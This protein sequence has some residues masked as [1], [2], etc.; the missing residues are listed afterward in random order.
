MTSHSGNWICVKCGNENYASR[1][2]CNMRKCGARRDGSGSGE[3]WICALC[4]NENYPSRSY[5]N[6]KTCGAPRESAD[7]KNAAQLVAASAVAAAQAPLAL[8]ASYPYYY[9]YTYPLTGSMGSTS[10]SSA[11]PPTSLPSTISPQMPGSLA[12][13]TGN[14]S[15][16]PLALSPAAA[17]A[18]AAA[19]WP[20]AMY[21][22]TGV[23]APP[24]DV[25]T[26]ANTKKRLN[27]DMNGQV[28][29]REAKRKRA[30]ARA[31][32]EG[33]WVCPNCGNL[34][35]PSRT[36]CNM[37][38]C[39]TPRPFPSSS[40]PNT[41]VHSAPSMVPAPHVESHVVTNHPDQLGTS[42]TQEQTTEG[43]IS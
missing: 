16:S 13:V 43:N 41:D 23:Y 38:K 7:T 22:L 30:A 25:G 20:Y 39:A 19:L 1:V 11:L 33:D 42:T 6:R 31:P 29:E 15:M 17:A 40:D 5:C 36:K 12:A 32:Q 21:P 18:A 28:D 2:F 8:A 14:S 9:P 37:K 10:L 3:N 4:G 26:T 27:S 24:V 35:Y 34:N